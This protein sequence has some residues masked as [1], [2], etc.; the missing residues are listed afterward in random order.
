MGFRFR[1]RRRSGGKK[2]GPTSFR[3]LGLIFCTFSILVAFMFVRDINLAKASASWP[4]VSGTVKSSRV[5]TSTRK[6][7]TKYHFDITYEYAVGGQSYSGSR[8]RFGG[9]GTTKSS[10]EE[11]V[12]SYPGGSTVT[13]HY[14]PDNP[15][16]CT[17]ETGATGERY[18]VLIFP[19]VFFLI[20]IGMLVGSF[21]VKPTPP[22]PVTGSV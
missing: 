16:E 1:N 19:G 11:L 15:S 13:V 14:F 17:L 22:V 8:V 12:K 2:F 10:A 20:G 9:A 6:G 3:V 18:A 5:S 7:K 21:Y 4:T